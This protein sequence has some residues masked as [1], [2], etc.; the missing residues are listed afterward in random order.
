MAETFDAYHEWLGIP[1]A[2]Q[3]PN[4]Y[5]LLG[6]ELFEDKPRV[7]ESAAD[8]RMAHLRSFQTGK[9]SA[10]SQKLLN[11]VAAAKLCLLNPQKKAPY[12]A[13]LREAMASQEASSSD[14]FGQRMA[15]IVGKAERAI[16]AHRPPASRRTAWLL[17]AG[18][19]ALVALAAVWLVWPSKKRN[20]LVPPK[21]V[22]VQ[23]KPVGSESREAHRPSGN[24]LS[25]DSGGPRT[26]RP[27]LSPNTCTASPAGFLAVG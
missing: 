23:P 27:T 24:D 5:R 9:H 26:T 22:A 8:Q 17:L 18:F 2:Q 3:P 16:P 13:R 6:I 19:W 4:D 25:N 15:E 11:E 14:S 7:I 12:D 1:P 21:L 20:D 10:L